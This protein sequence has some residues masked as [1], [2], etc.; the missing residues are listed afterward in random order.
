MSRK[1]PLEAVRKQIITLFP[2]YMIVFVMGCADG[3]LPNAM[4][5]FLAGEEV[6][7]T[8][9]QCSIISLAT[10][11]GRIIFAIPAGI[12]VDKYGRRNIAVCIAFL[13]FSA[14]VG[15][16]LSG[17]LV[18][19]YTGRFIIGLAEAMIYATSLVAIGEVASPEIRG[20]LLSIGLICINIGLLLPS[21][22]SVIFASY[23]VL[24]W[25][26]TI[27][28]GISLLSMFWMTETPS[29][30][31]SVSKLK[32]AKSILHNIRKGYKKH[33]INEEFE[34][35]KKY[36]E[37]EKTRRNELSWLKFLNTKSI[38]KPLITGILLNV[39]SILTGSVLIKIYITAIIPFNDFVPKKFYP[40]IIQSCLLCIAF[41][42]T[43][44]IDKFPRRIIFLFGAST[45]AIV[46]AICALAN[47]VATMDQ[48]QHVFKWIFIL[49]NMLSVICYGAAIQP[50]N[51]A[52]KAELYPQ[53]M[54]GFCGSLTIISQA[55]SFIIAFQLYNLIRSYCHLSLLYVIF[56]IN[57]L[58]L[59]SII[60]YF[61]PESRGESLVDLQK[62][63][64]EEIV[65]CDDV[66]VE[67]K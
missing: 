1:V 58:I 45:M 7:A 5:F 27:F 62:K 19:I 3:W 43:F 17:S 26:I 51:S 6:H 16:S 47:Y 63:F 59:C 61:L 21:I 35:L 8:T 29:H 31:V 46:N 12:L 28:T 34:E 56:S 14:W 18:T 23:R 25:G 4:Y 39:F 66:S 55:L 52:L 50:V 11:F 40:L 57:S 36:I 49:G 10:E 41:S 67:K 22:M 20:Q 9:S 64:N 53:A 13:F 54:K 33:E 24:S 2:V 37:D 44:Y 38:R 65:S 42:T 48:N 30:L 15:I 32:Q 60:Y